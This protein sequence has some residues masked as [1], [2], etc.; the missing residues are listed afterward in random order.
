M[1]YG[2]GTSH[3]FFNAG[4]GHSN[5]DTR[6]DS[7]ESELTGP[8]LHLG[9]TEETK[10]L[11]TQV[12]FQ[13]G[14]FEGGGLEGKQ[15]GWEAALALNIPYIKPRYIFGNS[16]L[17]FKGNEDLDRSV[18]FS[19][20]GVMLDIPISKKT[21]LYFIYD[22]YSRNS[23]IRIEG[24]RSPFDADFQRFS[25]GFRYHFATFKGLFN[26]SNDKRRRR[27]RY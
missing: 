14:N 22:D 12:N 20:W 10:F 1:L 5:I 24:I 4:V 19:G 3:Y 17:E 13:H 8:N 27:T 16:E 2:C 18:R 15:T 11:L 25:L 26:S 9:I 7:T 6:F 21:F 23:I